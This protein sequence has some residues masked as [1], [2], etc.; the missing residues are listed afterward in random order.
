MPSKNAWII[1]LDDDP[2]GVRL[3]ESLHI[4]EGGHHIMV[5][6]EDRE[7][8]LLAFH[9]G[10]TVCLLLPCRDECLVNALDHLLRGDIFLDAGVVNAHTAQPL[11][12][13]T[14]EGLPPANGLLARRDPVSK[15]LTLDA[16]TRLQTLTDRE[17]Q[18]VQLIKSGLSSKEIAVK[19]SIS[20]YT[21]STHTKHVYRKLGVSSRW[22]LRQ[23][24]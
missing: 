16:K 9:N 1:D 3:V 2:A 23:V 22:H 10:A 5:C 11:T 13:E 18:V 20:P 7:K 6:T 14:H 4:S 12:G 24:Y 17:K 15:A 21:V 8:A 19:L